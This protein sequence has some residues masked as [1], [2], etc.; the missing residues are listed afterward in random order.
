MAELMSLSFW[1]RKHAFWEK[2]VAEDSFEKSL[3]VITD[4]SYST[5]YF[6]E[7]DLT[8]IYGLI[9]MGFELYAWTGSLVKIDNAYE[10]KKALKNIQP[11]HP[12]QLEVILSQNEIE[13]DRVK[14]I[15]YFERR[16]IESILKSEGEI[17]PTLN[18]HD[19]ELNHSS[20]KNY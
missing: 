9:D 18:F 7:E 8:W 14:I 16:R 5:K 2:Q 15:D 6:R 19:I 11:I 17:E 20:R 13:K 1:E 12:S 3:I 4:W 10:I